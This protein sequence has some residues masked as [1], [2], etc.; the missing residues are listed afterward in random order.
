MVPCKIAAY[1]KHTVSDL[2]VI[3]HRYYVIVHGA[4]PMVETLKDPN[5]RL[6]LRLEDDGCVIGGI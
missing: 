6:T 5:I 4:S 1:K 2:G 3:P